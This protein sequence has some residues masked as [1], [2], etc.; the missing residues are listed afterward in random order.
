MSKIFLYLQKVHDLVHDLEFNSIKSILMK[1]DFSSPK[2]FTVGVN[3]SLWKQL[4]K[5][6]QKKALSKDWY[7]SKIITITVNHA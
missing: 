3:I 7:V 1:K 2:I 5:M 6:E 4:N